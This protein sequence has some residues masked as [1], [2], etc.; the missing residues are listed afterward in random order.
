MQSWYP[1]NTSVILHI[2]FYSPA[3]LLSF[4]TCWNPSPASSFMSTSTNN[5]QPYDIRSK[6]T[7]ILRPPFHGLRE[8]PCVI[9]CRSHDIHGTSANSV[10][11]SK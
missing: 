5:V 1:P 6:I 10:A 4:T 3:L 9:G 2:S 7:Y 11:S 8:I